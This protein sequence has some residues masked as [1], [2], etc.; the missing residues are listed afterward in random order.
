MIVGIDPG[1]KGAIAML[2]DAGHLYIED[3][4]MLGKEVNGGVLADI[5]KVF[6]PKAVYLEQVNSFGMGRTSAY[7]FG[8]GVGVIKGVLAAL[9]IPFFMVTPMKWK[10]HYGLNRDKDASRLLATRT[11]PEQ[12]DKFKLKKFDGRAEAALIAK[13]GEL[14]HDKRI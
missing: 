6:P 4:P 2:Y 1:Q 5:L 9:N 8:Q 14:Q 7:N 12:T 3:M 11:W 10:K 13:Y